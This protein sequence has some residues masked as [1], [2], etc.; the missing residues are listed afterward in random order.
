[1]GHSSDLFKLKN[2]DQHREF[3]LINTLRYNIKQHIKSRV[4][5][6]NFDL[7]Q[8]V[9]TIKLLEQNFGQFKDPECKLGKVAN[10]GELKTHKVVHWITIVHLQHL[11]EEALVKS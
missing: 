8:G 10:R 3:A 9:S 6:S 5:L 11:L 2:V 4:L 1:M 7:C